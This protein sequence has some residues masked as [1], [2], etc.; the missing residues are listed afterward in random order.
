MGNVNSFT[1]TVNQLVEQVNIALESVVK[2]NDSITTQSDSV[3]LTIEQPDPISGDVS[4]FT[5]SLPSYNNV[6]NKVNALGQTMDTFVKGEGKILLN[7]GTYREVTTIPVAISPSKITNVLAPTKFKTRSNWFFESIMFPQLVVS[8][9]L[10][11]K[12]DDRSDRVVVKRVIFDNYDDGETQWFLDHIIPT[13]RT[14]YDTITY[15]NEQGKQYW[16]DEEIQSLP[17][18]TE[19]YTGYFVITDIRTIE[20]KQWFYLDTTNYGVTSDAP[21]INDIQLSVGDTLRYENSIWKIDDI[22]LNEKRVHVVAN[23]GM[24]HPTINHSFEIYN[25][26]FS[27]KMLDIPVG[28]DECNIVFLKGVNDDFNIIGDDWSDSINFYSND[29]I[30][31]GGSTTLD[32][33]YNLYVSD[34]GL[35]MEGQAKEKFIPAYF[36]ITPDAPVIS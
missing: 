34:F 7:D 3:T 16:E 9:D 15:L 12:I 36:G 5:Y 32:D 33:Y 4:T 27:T 11:G 31:N 26:P 25:A 13:T 29:L 35:Q 8:F 22:H 20:G 6:I 30:I 1:E 10:K 18:S 21:V 28:F 19:P 24:D 2:L 14:Y 17:L 23:V